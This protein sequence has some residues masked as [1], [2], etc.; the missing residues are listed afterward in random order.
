MIDRNTYAQMRDRY[1]GSGEIDAPLYELLLRLVGAVVFTGG[2]PSA[3]SPTGRWNREAAM[4]A[5]H[6]W[7][8]RRLLQTNALLG[9]FDYAS[10]PRPFLRSLEQNFRHYLQNQRERGELDNLIRRTGA[11]LREDDRFR[12]WLPQA[13]IS[14]TWWGLASWEDPQ[15]FQGSDTDLVSEAWAVGDVTLFRYSHRVE[16]ASPVLSTSDLGDFLEA[17]LER[18]ASLITVAHLA[19]VFRDRFD[20][21][22]PER[23]ELVEG[24]ALEPAAEEELDQEAIAQAALSVAAELTERQFEV[25]IRRYRAETLD[26]IASGIRVSRGT[27]DNELRRVGQVIERHCADGITQRQILEKLLDALS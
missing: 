10:E 3:Y 18:V 23:L 15:P 19:V 4:E 6:G 21:G 7:I 14:D 1:R 12:D 5:A 20:I 24:G 11:L 27:V 25:L 2:L 22:E 17:L 8:E 16:R 13:R 26:E 9:A